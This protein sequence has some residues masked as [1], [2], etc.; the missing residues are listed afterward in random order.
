MSGLERRRCRGKLLPV[1]TAVQ[2]IHVDGVIRE[3]GQAGDEVAKD[4]ARLNQRGRSQVLLVRGLQD[5]VWGVVSEFG[6]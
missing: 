6:K 5:V 1:H 4:V 2:N 3:D